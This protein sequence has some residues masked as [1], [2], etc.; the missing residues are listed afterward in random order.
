MPSGA[1]PLNEMA[2]RKEAIKIKRSPKPKTAGINLEALNFV[3]FESTFCEFDKIGLYL[4][5]FPQK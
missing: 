4:L 2:I 5:K 3:I 1:F